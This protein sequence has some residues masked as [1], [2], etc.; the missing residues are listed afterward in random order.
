VSVRATH[1]DG[2][3]LERDVA[4]DAVDELLRELLDAG[5]HVREVRP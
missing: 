5:W 1:P 4:S 2:R 3:R